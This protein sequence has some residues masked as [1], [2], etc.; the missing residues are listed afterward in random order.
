M[1]KINQFSICPEHGG[2]ALYFDDANG[3]PAFFRYY[4][5]VKDAVYHLNWIL[6]TSALGLISRSSSR[7]SAV[8]L[9]FDF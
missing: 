1:I 5:S 8:Q 3:V 2:Y 4:K 7:Y 9:T 6:F